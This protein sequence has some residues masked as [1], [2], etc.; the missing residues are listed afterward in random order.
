MSEESGGASA[1][2]STVAAAASDV[3]T[4]RAVAEQM[5]TTLLAPLRPWSGPGP[6]PGR[7]TTETAPRARQHKAAYLKANLD[8]LES[9]FGAVTAATSRGGRR[10]GG[11]PPVA[12]RECRTC[13]QAFSSGRTPSELMTHLITLSVTECGGGSSGADPREKARR[14]AAEIRIRNFARTPAVGGAALASSL[15]LWTCRHCRNKVRGKTYHPLFLHLSNC[16]GIVPVMSEL[17]GI[18]RTPAYSATAATAATTTTSRPGI[19]DRANNG[20]GG[21][22][23][24]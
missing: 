8:Y 1:H 7:G 16:V 3:D 17:D 10:G 21:E 2:D 15:P 5:R 14:A 13:G 9:A 12:A 18:L 22:R 11:Q 23:P 6:R 20:R 19:G 4:D 24:S